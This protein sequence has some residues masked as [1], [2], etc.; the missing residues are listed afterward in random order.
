MHTNE[1]KVYWKDLCWFVGSIYIVTIKHN[2]QLVN[3][4]TMYVKRTS[5]INSTINKY[6][7]FIPLFAF[8]EFLFIDFGM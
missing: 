1:A 5:I 7:N 3:R 2:Y 6:Q 4:Y 8:V